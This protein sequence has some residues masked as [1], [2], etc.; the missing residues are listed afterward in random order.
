MTHCNEYMP[1]VTIPKCKMTH[2]NEYKPWV[3][4]PKCEMTHCNEYKPQVTIPKCEMTHCNEY[5]PRD[6]V[7]RFLPEGCWELSGIK[8]LLPV[9][10]G[11][12][13]A[14]NNKYSSSTQ[15]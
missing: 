12:L 11:S 3:T 2:C 6:L 15:K 4:I 14:N 7:L 1:R 9:N 13:E 8:T 5:K 10:R